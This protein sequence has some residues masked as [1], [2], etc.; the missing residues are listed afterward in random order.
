MPANSPFRN[1]RKTLIQDAQF[2]GYIV[3][4]PNKCLWKSDYIDGKKVVTMVK[5]GGLFQ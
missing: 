5:P 2:V 4:I 3:V 1:I